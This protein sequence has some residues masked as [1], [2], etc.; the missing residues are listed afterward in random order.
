M[1]IDLVKL[2][3]ENIYVLLLSS[4]IFGSISIYI[5]K[6][7]NNIYESK[8]L[9]YATDSSS[10]SRNNQSFALTSLLSE[11]STSDNA[12]FASK[13]L[14]SRDFFEI[15]Y[16]NNTFASQLMAYIN[17]DFL[18]KEDYLDKDLFNHSSGEWIVEKPPLELAHRTFLSKHFIFYET[19]D[20]GFYQLQIRHQSPQVAKDWSDIIIGE[21][22]RYVGLYKEK[23]ANQVLDFLLPQLAM[24]KNATIKLSMQNLITKKYQD[25]AFSKNEDYV[26][27]VISK[28]YVPIKK[29]SPNRPLIC[30]AITFMGIILTSLILIFKEILKK[31][32]LLNL[33]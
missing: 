31:R 15:L 17:Y 13:M 32:S 30:F 27:S 28:P 2:I 25:L 19:S 4:F 1:K 10:S 11:N 7:I 29:S 3:K 16:E 9:L 18:N 14:F 21:I 8:A 33:K 5:A 22:N 6:S 26:F 20:M 23:T 12:Q 24:E